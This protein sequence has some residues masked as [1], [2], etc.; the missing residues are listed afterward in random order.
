MP[1]W[2][3]C[4]L[5]PQ[6]GADRRGD[7]VTL[8]VEVV[9]DLHRVARFPLVVVFVHRRLEQ[10]RIATL[11]VAH[12]LHSFLD[13]LGEHRRLVAHERPHLLVNLDLRRLRVSTAH[14][15]YLFVSGP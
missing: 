13:R 15:N 7:T 9:A 8:G 11:R 12:P 2:C 3:C 1:M 5:I 10:E 14:I 6:V 4:Q